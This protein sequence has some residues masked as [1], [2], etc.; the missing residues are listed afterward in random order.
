MCAVNGADGADD[1]ILL[2]SVVVPLAKKKTGGPSPIPLVFLKAK[3]FIIAV[4]GG[5][6]VPRFFL[7]MTIVYLE[8]N[9]LRCGILSFRFKGSLDGDNV[10][11]EW[12]DGDC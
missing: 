5:E 9:P 11:R 6:E 10:C 3:G 1:W 12:A 4:N 7:P 8:V 2:H